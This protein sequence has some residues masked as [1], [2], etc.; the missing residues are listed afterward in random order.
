MSNLNP[1]WINL[2]FVIDKSG[3]MWSSESDVIGGFNKT[4]EEQKAIE[5]G[6][7]TVSM[8]TFDSTVHELYIGKDIND[9]PKFDY[10]ADGMTAMNDG[11]GTAIDNVGK[12]LYNKDKS[13]EEM[14]GKTL[15]VVMTD[16]MENSSTEYTLKQV[17][18]RIK[19]QT[20]K[21]SWEFI[22]MGTDITTTKAADTLGFKFKTYSSRAKV[23][24]NYDIIN[25]AT[26][27]YRSMAATGASL[28][29]TSLAFCATLD[30]EA[31]KNTKA[32]EKEIG[33]KITSV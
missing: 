17:Q 2:V 32:Y 33:K 24:S 5:D 1:K 10:H 11:I 14:P 7:V 25:C 22:Y 31:T 29:D 4:I 6:K 26:T 27:M 28:A 21:Y 23:A 9:L 30:E 20:E 3:S 12:W 16:G 18:D 19:E 15:V 8:F 13:N